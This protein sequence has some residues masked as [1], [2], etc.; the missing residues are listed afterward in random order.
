M[1]GDVRQRMID[2]TVVLLA[3]HGLSGTSFSDVLAAS[4]APRG[5]L[6]HHFPG[7][8]DQLVL[9][10]V[11]AAGD[12]AMGVLDQLTGRPAGEVADAFLALWRSVLTASGL[13][14]GCAVAAVTVAS[15]SAA[16]LDRVGEVFRGWRIR[17]AALFVEGGVPQE[18]AT[19][20]A[21][22]LIAASEGAVVL[23]RAE[24]SLEPFDLVAA[25]QL[26]AVRRAS[27]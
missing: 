13:G 18:R 14:A 27:R 4:G 19:A 2:S 3:K 23:A 12:R 25:D 15:D 5:S 21:T 10:A 7:G 1:A 20:L 17:L 24:R 11:T 16:M 6:Y 22:T 8:K 26:E 9:A